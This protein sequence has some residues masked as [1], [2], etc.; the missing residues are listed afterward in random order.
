MKLAARASAYSRRPSSADHRPST[1]RPRFATRTCVCSC[2]S[3]ARDVRCRNAAATSPDASS[4]IA[5]A[6]PRRTAAADRSRWPTASRTATSCASRTRARSSSSPSPKSTLT[7]FGAENVRSKPATRAR[8]DDVRSSE[9]S[10]GSSPSSTRRSASAPT[11]PPSPSSRAADADP[12][13]ARL[14][15]PDVV[16]LDARRRRSAPRRPAPPPGRGSTWPGRPRACRSKA[17]FR[18]LHLLSRRARVLG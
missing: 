1:P 17:R 15:R 9:P 14:A 16:V 7:L 18:A 11:S 5:P 8:L 13:T 10:R 6:C 4:T 12:P 2:G 3:P